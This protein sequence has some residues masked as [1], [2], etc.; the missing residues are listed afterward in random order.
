MNASETGNCDVCKKSD[1]PINRK[2]F[3]YD[4]KCMCHSPVHFELVYHCNDCIPTPPDKTTIYIE[5][6]D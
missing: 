3:H 1:I 6:I 2:Y 5:P 4:I